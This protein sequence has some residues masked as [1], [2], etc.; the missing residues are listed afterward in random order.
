MSSN[1]SF[2]TTAGASQSTVQPRLEGNNIYTVKFDGCEIKEFEG[3]QD[4]NKGQIYKTL[5]I[6][7]SNEDGV[8]EH[9]FFE[10]KGSDFERT[11]TEFTD[12]TGK[13]NKIPQPSNVESMM[14]NFKHIIDAINPKVAAQIDSKEKNLGAKSWDDLRTLVGKILDAGKGTETKIKLV[15]NK[16]GEAIIPGFNVGVNKDGKA[17]IKNNW[18]GSK[19]AFSSYELDR[20]NKEAIAKP[21]KVSSSLDLP[22]ENT[23]NDDLIDDLGLDLDL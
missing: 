7:F 9:N 14:L 2:S 1:F 16:K 22:V 13:V 18:I 10:P 23:S 21:T 4:H 15:K 19:I 20:I 5:V 12:K 17:Y 11:E 6:K 3:K 8:F